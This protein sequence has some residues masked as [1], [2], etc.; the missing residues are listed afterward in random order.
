M[1]L[2]K[3]DRSSDVQIGDTVAIGHAERFFVLQIGSDPL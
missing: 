2:V 1:R 3:S